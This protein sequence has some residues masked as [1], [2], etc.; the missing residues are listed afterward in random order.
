MSDLE[1]LEVKIVQCNCSQHG[2]LSDHYPWCSL[3]MIRARNAR[4]IELEG[5]KAASWPLVVM[6]YADAKAKL[7]HAE[8]VVEAAREVV[9]DGRPEP[10]YFA[11]VNVQ[12]VIMDTLTQSLKGYDN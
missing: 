11:Y 2:E 8:K 5:E 10:I 7:S 6:A 1:S 12:G 9:R 3:R 4:I